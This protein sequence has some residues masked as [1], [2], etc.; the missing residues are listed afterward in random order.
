MEVV[1]VVATDVVAPDDVGA[2]VV[3]AALVGAALVGAALVGAALVRRGLVPASEQA[4]RTRTTTTE[5]AERRPRASTSPPC[6]RHPA[7]VRRL[8][9]APGKCREALVRAGGR[10]L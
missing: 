1:T 8:P 3:G 4:A 9:T 2:A 7:G 6:H 5:A 10:R